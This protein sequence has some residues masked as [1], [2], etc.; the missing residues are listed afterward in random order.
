MKKLRVFYEGWGERWPLATLADDGQHLLFEYSAEAL[1]QGLE[2]SPRHLPLRAQ[3]YGD[4]PHHQMRLPG[5]VADALP[6]GWGLVLMDRLFRKAGRAPSGLSPLERLAFVGGR[7]MGALAFEPAEPL[8]LRGEGVQLLALAQQAQ[9][10]VADKDTEALKTLALMGGSPH[11]ARPKVLVFHNPSTGH[12]SNQPF[13]GAGAWLVKF[14]AQAEHKEVCAIE[15]LYAELART[16][17]LDIPPTRYFDLD[18][19]LAGFGIERFDMAR[20][21]RVPV[22]TLA[23]L[24]H[25]NFRL[26]SAV[27]YG[28][29]LRAT[30]F[31]TRSQVEVNKA[32]QRAVF[33]VL[34]NNRDDHA[35]NISFRLSQDRTWHLAPAYDLTYC[36]GP[37]GEHQMDVCGEGHTITRHHMLE[38]AKQGGVPLPFAQGCLERAMDLVDAL[39]TMAKHHPIRQTTWRAIQSSI[40]SNRS[41]LQ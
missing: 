38:L 29:F 2:L 41:H 19:K 36:E 14:Q 22:H 10:V 18:K 40:K 35:K 13:E 32:Y 16:F 33:N 34:F 4:F 6:D 21:M 15:N 12:M 23:G 1:Q 20:G 37:G 17:G 31:F 11:G 9:V 25:A 8:A 39:P 3:A 30:R 24:L 28:T 5:L 26:P 7:A 27:D